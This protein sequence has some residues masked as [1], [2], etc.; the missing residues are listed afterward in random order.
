M[1]DPLGKAV[2]HFAK[3]DFH[4][5]WRISPRSNLEQLFRPLVSSAV[6]RF[7]V[8]DDPQYR[9][10]RAHGWEDIPI[11]SRALRTMC[12]FGRYVGW[13]RNVSLCKRRT[14]IDKPSVP[15]NWQVHSKLTSISFTDG[16]ENWLL[17]PSSPS[18]HIRLPVITHHL[19]RQGS[20]P[21]SFGIDFVVLLKESSAQRFD[22]SV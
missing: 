21:L 13:P 10:S 16:S 20:P 1:R 7:H 18:T 5:I 14:E 11:R 9:R 8:I 6:L 15:L 12:V 3:I 17:H 4:T 22:W 19:V 2:L